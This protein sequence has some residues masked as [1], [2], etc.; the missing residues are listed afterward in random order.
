MAGVK[1]A[2][3]FILRQQE[4]YPA[5]VVD[6]GW[7]IVG[8]ND[9]AL[10]LRRAFLDDAHYAA[11]GAAA[12]NAMKLIFDPLLYRPFV[13]AWEGIARQ[14]LQ[15]LRHEARADSHGETAARLLQEL[16]DYPEV[17]RP[18]PEVA[19]RPNEP[20]MTVTLRKGDLQVKYFSTLSTFG[21]PQ[22]TSDASGERRIGRDDF[23]AFVD[24]DNLVRSYQLAARGKRGA[25]SVASFEY[26]LGERLLSLRRDLVAG[27]WRPG[28]YVHFAIHEPKRRWI[29]AAPFADR[30]VHHALCRVLEPAFET[31]FIADSFANR[32]GKGTHRAVDRL[33]MLCR[34]RAW[35]LRLDIR[36]YFPSIDHDKLLGILYRRIEDERIR[37][38]VGRIVASGADIH[39]ADA[40]TA[41]FPGDDLLALTRPRGLPIGNL[42]SQFWSN[43]YLDRL[44]HFVRRTLR[45]DDYLRYVDDFALFHDDK[46]QLAVWR[47][48]II[49]FL[50]REL[51]LRVHENSAQPA[52]CKAGIPWLGFVVFPHHRRVKARKVVAATRRLTANYEAWCRDDISFAEFDASVGGWINHVRYADSWGLRT[53]VLSRFALEGR[54]IGKTP[55]KTAARRAARAARGQGS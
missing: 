42:T 53:H 33:Q 35:A 50:G 26:A 30:V 36:R 49:A 45:C 2:L 54:A 19:L 52:L 5:L 25:D 28:P 27:T 4:P 10:R 46:G 1:T 38:V 31:R 11:A 55:S 43:C 51:R 40:D 34:K 37:E 6:R 15:R 8:R 21:T 17:P 14:I 7:N 22:D 16:L 3:N 32:V 41:L 23:D 24:W 47:E 20:L 44:D 12:R 39:A 48:Q 9:A 13:V 18:G 29:S